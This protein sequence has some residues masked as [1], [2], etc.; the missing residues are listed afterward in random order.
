MFAA[1]P[2]LVTPRADPGVPVFSM[3][4]YAGAR[5]RIS[6]VYLLN[7]LAQLGFAGLWGLAE[8]LETREAHRLPEAAFA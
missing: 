3:G 8:W 6:R 2:V 5:R 4:R 1:A 7:G